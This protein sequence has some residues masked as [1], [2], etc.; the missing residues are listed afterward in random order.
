MNGNQWYAASAPVSR[1]SVQRIV[2]GEAATTDATVTT[3][4]T[5]PIQENEAVLLTV[6]VVGMELTLGTERCAYIRQVLVYRTTTGSA[7]LES[8]Q[9]EP[10]T[11]ETS[12]G[13][14]ANIIVS[15][16]NAL[17]QVTG[18]AAINMDWRAEA[19]LTRIVG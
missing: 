17:V 10:L 1:N 16:F 14:D 9:D 4:V 13:L 12:A 8:L 11:R 3:I 6:R 5:L 7:A 2:S 18:L 19:T 15:G